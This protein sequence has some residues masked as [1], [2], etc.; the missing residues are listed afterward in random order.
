MFPGTLWLL[1][2]NWH[3]SVF[4][5]DSLVEWLWSHCQRKMTMIILK[6]RRERA[7]PRSRLLTTKEQLSFQG[8]LLQAFEDKDE[9]FL[10]R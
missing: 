5:E 1:S 4:I 2:V 9:L 8:L 7:A 10:K 3:E 6:V